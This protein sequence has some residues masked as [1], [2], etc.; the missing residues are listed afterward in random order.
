[1]GKSAGRHVDVAEIG[2][3]LAQVVEVV[4]QSQG[5]ADILSSGSP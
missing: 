1:M 5:R 4:R 2:A 3:D